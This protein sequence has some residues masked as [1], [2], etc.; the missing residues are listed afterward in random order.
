MKGGDRSDELV[1]WRIKP[2]EHRVGF[3]VPRYHACQWWRKRLLCAGC[4]GK[5]LNQG[6]KTVTLNNGLDI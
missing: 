4:D 3:G 1:V 2:V 5:H 6:V